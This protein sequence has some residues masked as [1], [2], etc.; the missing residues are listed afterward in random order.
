MRGVAANQSGLAFG[1]FGQQIAA[2]ITRCQT[3][4]AQTAQQNVCKVL[5][6]TL[7]LLQSFESGCVDVGAFAGVGEFLVNP[8]HQFAS[9]LQ[10]RFVGAE[11]GA[12]VVC[13]GGVDGH[14]G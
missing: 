5:A 1:W 13:K 12:C 9:S 10:H 4:G 14:I 2:D 7:A 3:L 6:H 8:F 11:G